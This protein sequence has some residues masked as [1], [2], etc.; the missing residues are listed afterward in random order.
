MAM[1]LASTQLSVA[2]II[3]MDHQKVMEQIMELEKR[4]QGRPTSQ[5]PV[6]PTMKKMLLGHM[7]AEEKLF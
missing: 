7:A 5:H 2:D 1:Q 6:F 4:V 3:K